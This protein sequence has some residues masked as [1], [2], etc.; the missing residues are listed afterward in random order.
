MDALTLIAVA[1]AASAT[2]DTPVWWL[3][4]ATAL[5]AAGALGAVYQ[6]REVRRDR[7]VSAFVHMGTRWEGA[8]MTEALQME[9]NYTP[10]ELAELFARVHA[11]KTNRK[12]NPVEERKRIQEAEA[13][14]VLLRVPYYFEDF[15]VIT[16]VGGLNPEKVSEY[17]GG[18]AIDEWKIWGPTIKQMQLQD[19]W[20]FE[21]FERMATT[22]YPARPMGWRA[23]LTRAQRPGWPEFTTEFD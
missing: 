10:E 14:I 18:L 21:E 7:H 9:V 13:A 8:E 4:G 22:V 3:V 11:A 5:V 2:S 17:V 20:E 15:A 12:R 6:L 1:L 16:S 19:G 23:R